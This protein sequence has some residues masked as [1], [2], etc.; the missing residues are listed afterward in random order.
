MGTKVSALGTWLDGVP[1]GMMPQTYRAYTEEI[2]RLQEESGVRRQAKRSTNHSDRGSKRLL[3]TKEAA[4]YLGMSTWSLRQEVNNGELHFVS[5]G[6]HTS[7]WKF[8]VR[9]LDAWIERHKIKY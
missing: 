4:H 1:V 8:D 3:R 5:S 2:E 9:D 6:E 7:S